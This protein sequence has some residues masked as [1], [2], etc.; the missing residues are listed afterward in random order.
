MGG[1]VT[2]LSRTKSNGSI[3]GISSMASTHAP[4]FMAPSM[5]K[6]YFTANS[7][8][9]SPSNF[10]SSW[11]AAVSR[12]LALPLAAQSSP[13]QSEL[14]QRR[15]AK[16]VTRLPKA[17]LWI[18]VSS[19]LIFAIIGLGLAAA[20]LT[21]KS[22]DAHQVHTRLGVAGLAAAL[23]ETQ[24]SH[25]VAR[26]DSKLFEENVERMNGSISKKVGVRLTG[27]GGASFVLNQ[28]RGR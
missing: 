3:A 17:A 11:K 24:H 5:A 9:T 7:V 8:Q 19:N 28:F 16:V 15:V 4:N 14:V 21:R 25:R 2:E 27:E 23:F 10:V 12:A 26:E 18:L 22:M 6:A 1:K 20:A 13:R